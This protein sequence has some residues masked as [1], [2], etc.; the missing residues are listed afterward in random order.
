MKKIVREYQKV[1]TE[2]LVECESDEEAMSKVAN[3]DSDIVEI[4]VM[5]E[6]VST[7]DM[8]VR[9]ITSKDTRDPVFLRAFS[10]LSEAEESKK[11]SVSDIDI[12][13]EMC[14]D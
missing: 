9:N 12:L 5:P 4:N 7:L 13:L 1:V 6:F 10:M 14:R 8:S 2:Y 11:I 3:L